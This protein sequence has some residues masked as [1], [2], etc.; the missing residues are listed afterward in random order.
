[1]SKLVLLGG[2]SASGKT[3]VVNEV[4]KRLPKDKVTF[5]SLDDYYK[6]FS[7]LP[8]EERVKI[9]F[10]HPKL[11]GDIKDLIM[12][13]CTK[14]EEFR[15]EIEDIKKHKYFSDID[16]DKVLRKEYGNIVTVKKNS[17]KK[18]N[19]NETNDDS[20][21]EDIEYKK[22]MEQQKIIDEDKSLN[23]LNGKIT[24]KEMKLDQQKKI[25]NTVREFYF[26]KKEDIDKAQEFKLEIKGDN[27]D[28]SSLI[29]E[30]YDT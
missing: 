6:D 19:K 16:F 21:N 15:I 24:L 9:N 22:F 18:K 28:I 27:E 3:Y 10:D 11:E 13:M 17:K 4:L 5:I 7:V 30:Q 14:E 20:L 2:G 1:M 25:I 23:I 12:K 29:I 26:V 8:M